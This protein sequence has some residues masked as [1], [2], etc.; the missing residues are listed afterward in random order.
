MK[1]AFLFPGQGAQYVGM[2]HDLYDAF[3][4][5]RQCF[6]EANRLLEEPITDI[7]F[8]AE[9]SAED[10]E[11]LLRQTEYT[12]PALFVHSVAVHTV[13]EDAGIAPAMTAGHSLGEYSALVAAGAITFE[14]GVLAV[15]ERGRLMA[16]SGDIRKG[17]MAA[18]LGMDEESVERICEEASDETNEIAQPAN[19]NT[20]D[21]IV[22]SGDIQAVETAVELA[23]EYDL[24]RAIPLSVS[25]AFHSPLMKSA[26][27][28]LAKT[29]ADLRIA[30]PEC[31]VYLNVSATPTTDPDTIREGLLEQLTAPV[32]WAQTLRNMGNDG[33]ERYIEVGAGKVLSGLVKRTLGRQAVWQLAGTAEQVNQLLSEA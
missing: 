30:E 31:P 1:N 3:P 4:A 2:G 8:G 6:D 26:R 23:H 15:A 24:G 13:L 16:E 22:I 14:D 17:T 9:T 27:D 29:L 11:A 21:Q 32:L 25:G 28:G 18:M 12:Q 5:A 19:Y 20:P 33:A 7:M 10:A